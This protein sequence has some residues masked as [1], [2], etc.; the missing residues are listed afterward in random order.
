MF[1]L[2]RLLPQLKRGKRKETSG[3]EIRF[4]WKERAKE[5]EAKQDG[6]KNR[7]S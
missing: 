7:V 6:M 3:K 4:E 5:P 2:L 1:T